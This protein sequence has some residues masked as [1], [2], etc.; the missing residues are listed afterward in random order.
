MTDPTDLDAAV[1]AAARAHPILGAYAPPQ[2]AAQTLPELV[3]TCGT[4]G[5]LSAGDYPRHLLEAAVDA[6]D[7]PARDARIRA[8]ALRP[9]RVAVELTVQ[10]VRAQRGDRVAEIVEES[11]A[12]HLAAASSGE[13]DQ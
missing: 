11:F 1:E 10:D 2:G 13:A 5:H 3:V 7:L 8:E 4:C 9:V 12:A 6:L